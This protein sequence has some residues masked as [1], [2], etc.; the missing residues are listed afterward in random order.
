[1][2]ATRSALRAYALEDEAPASVVA[3]LWRFVAEFE[4]GQMA[5][6]LYGVLDPAEGSLR[7][8]SAAHPGPM[9]VH[10]DG[11]V[12][13]VHATPAAPLG[14]GGPPPD[15]ET[16]VRI[17]DGAALLLYTEALVEQRR[18]RLAER[19]ARLADVA[20]HAPDDAESLCSHLI[21]RMLDGRRPDDDVALLAAQPAPAPGDV[22]SYTIPAEAVELSGVRRGLRRWLGV[23]HAAE[24]EISA[25]TLACQEACANAIEHAYGLG[26]A[27]FDVEATHDGARVEI[28]VR[29]RGHWRA[30]RGRHRGRGFALMN[31][32]VDEVGIDHDERGTTVRLV[33]RL[34]TDR[35]L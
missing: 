7:F 12:A 15:G 30:P 8:S 6:L 20:A 13:F 24:N 22:L 25:I 16:E 4:H 28:T 32:L 34:E 26:D 11:D 9:I 10:P 21:S 3:R 29:D 35:T 5:T 33:R 31:H 1:M 23:L 19:R 14:V 18:A 2:G 17:A 27:T